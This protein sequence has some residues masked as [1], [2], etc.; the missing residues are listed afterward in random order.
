MDY[1]NRLVCQAKAITSQIEYA[2]IMKHCALSRVWQL[3][4]LC[5]VILQAAH[6]QSPYDL[7]ITGGRVVDPQSGLD[8]VR[9]VAIAG[10][11]IVAVSPQPLEG[12]ETIDATGLVVAPGFIDLHQHSQTDEAYRAK[13][14]D[15]VTTALEMEE[16][17][18]DIDGFYAERM[19]KA[20][21]NFGATIGHEYLRAAVVK[22]GKADQSS[23]DAG[24]RNLSKVEIDELRK[25]VEYS[26]RRGA[27]GVGV[28]MLDTPGATPAEILEM[29]RAAAEFKGAPVHIHVRDLQE[30]Q[31]W[32]ETDEVLADSMITGAPVQIVHANSSYREDAPQLFAM[33]KAARAR[34]V[35]VTTEAYP[36]TASASSLGSAPD[37]WEQWPDSKF[38]E[39]EWAATGERLTRENFAKYRNTGGLVIHYAMSESVLL[40]SVISPLTMI[41]S[42]GILKDGV[43]HPRAAGT[44]SRVLGRYVRE[45]KAI[46]LIDALRKMTVMPA[47]HLEARVPEMKNKGR[48]AL[49]ADADITIFD[50]ATVIDRAT[51]REPSKPSE[52]IAYVLVN[53]VIVVDRG[54]LRPNVF[55]GKGIRAPLN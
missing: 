20:R 14:L 22:K 24:K 54:K 35:D 30:P 41:A 55:P 47:Q 7:V 13:V 12:R 32:L 16:G 53:G 37:N 19:G 34:G 50:P 27:V 42:D 6:A 43:G 17:V 10:G 38:Q 4:L 29:F 11:R 36:Y 28:L 9:T 21:I 8:A 18:P 2:V 3:L 46:S 25:Q 26:L 44:F 51:Y 49:G 40:P 39:F 31:Y 48:I 33:L 52:G 23:G 15:G 45:Q 5:V 1:R